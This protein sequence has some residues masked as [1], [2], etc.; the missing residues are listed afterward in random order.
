MLMLNVHCTK[1][2]SSSRDRDDLSIGFQRGIDVR[3]RELTNNK[4]IEEIS[5]LKFI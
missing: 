3:E 2:I 1:I 5:M 4:T